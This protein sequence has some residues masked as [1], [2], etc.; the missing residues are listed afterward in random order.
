MSNLQL[1]L[2]IAGVVVLAVVVA[3]GAWTSRKNRPRQA[4]NS[5]ESTEQAAQTD[6]PDDSDERQDPA[7]DGSL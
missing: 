4:T 1:G 2:A 3:H 6:A 7:F 5:S